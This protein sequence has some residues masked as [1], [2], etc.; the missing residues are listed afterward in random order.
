MSQLFLGLFEVFLHGL[1][2]LHQTGELSF[3]E[4]DFPLIKLEN[5]KLEKFMQA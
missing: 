2:L 4:H 5:D 3:V 1:R